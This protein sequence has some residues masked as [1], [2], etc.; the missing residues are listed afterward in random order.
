VIVLLIAVGVFAW[1]LSRRSYF[2]ALSLLIAYILCFPL[3]SSLTQSRII[4][5]K[6]GNPEAEIHNDAAA[7]VATAVD[8]FYARTQEWPRSWND[9]D[10]DITNVIDEIVQKQKPSTADPFASAADPFTGDPFANEESQSIFSRAPDLG[11]TT[12]KDIRNLVDIDFDS[13]PK[14]LARMNWV[15][16][17][18][19]VPHNPAYNFYRVEFGKLIDRLNALAGFPTTTPVINRDS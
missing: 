14:A 3:L 9:L 19:I 17:D 10:N 15:E 16:F 12:A 4:A 18:G 6:R 13:D 7:I 1:L 5:P 11:N 2:G 8:R